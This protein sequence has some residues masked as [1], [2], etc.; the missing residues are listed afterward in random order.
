MMKRDLA[1]SFN[2]VSDESKVSSYRIFVVKATNYSSFNL[3]A[4]NA[5][6]SSNYTQVNKT[7]SNI[8]QILS[9]GARD[10][11]GALI[12]TG[13]G[14]RVFVMGV[15][16]G[17]NTANNLLSAASSAIT[18]SSVNVSNLSVSDVSDFGDA[19]GFKSIL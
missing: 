5:V 10:V 12:K 15:D 19:T 6:S 2:K 9:S 14:Y 11:D 13:V 7:G 8:T 16:S 18:L 4:A 1:V 17:S 3:A